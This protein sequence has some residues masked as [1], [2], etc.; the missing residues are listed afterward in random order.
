MYTYDSRKIS[1]GD[2]FI[3]LPGGEPYIEEAY[4]RGAEDVVH[5]TREQMAEF[6]DHYFGQPSKDL[7]VIGVTGTNGKTTV[8]T[9]VH[10][11]LKQSGYQSCIIGTLN[12]TLTTPESLDLQQMMY[13][14][15]CLGG[16]HFIME[17]SSHG[18]DQHRVSHIQFD[19]K[20]LTNLTQDH[21]D[22]HGTIEAYHATKNRF[23][24]EWSGLAIY[25]KDFESLHLPFETPLKGEFNLRNM[26]SVVAIL[27]AALI[28]ESDIKNS[29]SRALAPPGRFESIEE[30]QPFTVIVDYAHTPDGLD[31][32]LK[33]ALDIAHAQDGR[34]ITV[35]GCGGDRDT[36]KRPKMGRIAS[37][38]SD[39]VVVT[40]DNPRSES[41]DQ[42]ISDILDGFS[43]GFD[44]Y[45][46]I[47]D[48]KE[49]I[50]KALELASKND[51]VV[52]AGK[53]HEN[54]QILASGTIHFDDREIARDL[55][56]KRI[57]YES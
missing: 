12:H 55:L 29:L 30:G 18:I 28:D 17:V 10:N 53:G 9:L 46:V 44:R 3:C 52:I 16:T 54:T 50:A 6:A 7:F 40:Q 15:A 2:T 24:S 14:H 37:I 23:M 21:L 33:E 47:S 56:R 19:V 11:A 4:A 5:M 27:R 45:E 41:E 51:V 1:P 20:C 31:V 49:A 38:W 35:F 32:V 25:P 39:F 36:T 13:D 8:S 34:L 42:I 26:Q 43:L 22:Y 48:R 57:V